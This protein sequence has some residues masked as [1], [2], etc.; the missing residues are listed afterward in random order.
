MID[1]DG[2]SV[3]ESDATVGN[4]RTAAIQRDQDE[5][6]AGRSFVQLRELE[7]TKDFLNRSSNYH[8]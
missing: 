7:R 3:E 1:I 2:R 8:L 4:G 6:L 5:D